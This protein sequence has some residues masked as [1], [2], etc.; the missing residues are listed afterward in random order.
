MGVL[1]VLP[2]NLHNPNPFNTI[3]MI[4][5]WSLVIVSA[6]FYRM[7]MVFLT[8]V[9]YSYGET[10]LSVSILFQYGGQ[11]YYVNANKFNHTYTSF[12]YKS[13]NC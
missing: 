13:Y 12:H 1:I 5:G 4:L 9:S 2:P 10:G 11:L 8:N 6:I 3:I 7:F